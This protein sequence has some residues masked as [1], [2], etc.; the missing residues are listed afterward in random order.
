M[1]LAQEQPAALGGHALDFAAQL[2]PL[3]ALDPLLLL[4]GRGHAHRGQLPGAA[5]HITVQAQGQFPGVAGVVIDA[6]VTF[7]QTHGLRHHVVHPQADQFAVQTVAEGPRLVAAG[8]GVGQGELGFDPPAKLLPAEALGGLG[9]AVIQDPHHD[10]AV[11][12]DVQ[13]QFDV[14]IWFARGLLR[15]NFGVIDFR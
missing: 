10:N 6:G 1:A 13:C 7:V 8:D 3:P 15:A 12:V 11:G 9:G 4:L 5:R 2:F 14:L